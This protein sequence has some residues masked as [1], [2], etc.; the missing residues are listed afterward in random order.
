MVLCTPE[1][2]R[3]G[4]RAKKE[5]IDK[6]ISQ[7]PKGHGSFVKSLDSKTRNVFVDAYQTKS[8][9]KS[10]NA[11]CID[12]CGFIKS[13][14]ALCEAYTCPLWEVRPYQAKGKK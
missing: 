9:R 13:E 14:I 3:E 1:Q 4:E 8:L 11:K 10:V 5:K 6:F 12:C 2:R 7:N